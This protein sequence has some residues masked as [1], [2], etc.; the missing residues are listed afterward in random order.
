MVLM[1][2]LRFI[3]ADGR[4]TGKYLVCDQTVTRDKNESNNQDIYSYNAAK[5]D[6][7]L[8]LVGIPGVEPFSIPVTYKGDELVYSSNDMQDGK[9]VFNRT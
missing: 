4:Q 2:N 5:D 3:P 6:F 7:K 1:I 9:K 8:L